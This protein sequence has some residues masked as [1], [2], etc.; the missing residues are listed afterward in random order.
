M[1]RH[2]GGIAALSAAGLGTL[3]L[4]TPIASGQSLFTGIGFLPGG[5]LISTS[6]TEAV[7]PDGSVVVGRGDRV[8]VSPFTESARWTRA[9]GLQGMG[10]PSGIQF[11][12]GTG[13]SLGG[14]FICGYHENLDQRYRAYRW[15]S[16]VGA[17]Q[18]LGAAPGGFSNSFAQDISRDGKVVVGFGRTG[19]A[20]NGL[21]FIWRDGVGMMS[22]GDLPGGAV[23][24]VALGISS[25]GRVV[26]GAS[27]DAES[28]RPVVW[29]EGA[30]L[31]VLPDL[32]GA[33]GFGLA[34]AASNDGRFIVG[35]SHSSL[36]YEAVLWKGYGTV[37]VGLGDLPGGQ[38]SG[39]ALGVT[40]DASMIVGYSSAAAGERGFIWSAARG[41]R[42]AKTV[43]QADYGL[44]LTG[45][46][47]GRV[48]SISADGTVLTG[49]GAD[50]RGVFQGWVA[51]I[52]SPSTAVVLLSVLTMPA[53]RRR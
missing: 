28:D 11:S 31:T 19:I 37:A 34:F 8:P 53:R 9:G 26:V 3:G 45:W 43:L 12:T 30:G 47:I 33:T 35:Y 7:A 51:V 29:R 48:N 1:Q 16:A 15:N 50:P 42:D 18:D 24:S 27:G 49:D 21:G 46:T 22:M 5:G 36:G 2:A 14:A 44:N 39:V 32:P 6:W 23:N 52:P 40:D 20:G 38:A 17:Y 4:V 13:A 25:D 41:M 10:L